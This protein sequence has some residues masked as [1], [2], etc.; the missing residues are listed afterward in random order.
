MRA[1]GEFIDIKEDEYTKYL[2]KDYTLRIFKNFLINTRNSINLLAFPIILIADGFRSAKYSS[3]MITEMVKNGL[4][5]KLKDPN[6]KDE[7]EEFSTKFREV[8]IGLTYEKD[9]VKEAGEYF[10]YLT[11][12]NELIRN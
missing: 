12:K 8:V 9:V 5:D 4:A 11:S 3:L 10:T 7:L 6:F 2:T 1:E